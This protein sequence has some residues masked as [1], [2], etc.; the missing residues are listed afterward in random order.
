MKQVWRTTLIVPE[1]ELFV[2]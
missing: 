1:H 2:R